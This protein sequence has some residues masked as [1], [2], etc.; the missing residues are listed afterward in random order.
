MLLVALRNKDSM[1]DH[2]YKLILASMSCR[3]LVVCIVPFDR[4][5][6]DWKT[7]LD[8]VTK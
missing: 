1:D 4:Y 6:V 8:E 3:S 2:S 5:I 7:D